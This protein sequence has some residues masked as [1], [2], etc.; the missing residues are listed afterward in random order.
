VTAKPGPALLWPTLLS[1]AAFA[2]LIGLGTWQMQRKSWKDGLIAQ[3][4]ARTTAPPIA[5]AEAIERMRKAESL[6]YTR[7]VVTG[8]WLPGREQHYWT[9]TPAGPGWHIYAPLATTDGPIVIVNR[10]FVPDARRDPALRPE[11]PAPA[12]VQLVGLLRKAEVRTT[13]TPDNV[14]ARNIWYWRDLDGMARSMLADA[15]GP[16][17]PFF[18]D[19][20]RGSA[21]PQAPQ[22]GVTRLDLP[23]THLQ[24]ALTWYGLAATLVGVYAA[25]AWGRLQQR[26]EPGRPPT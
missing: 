25:F 8:R 5:F 13:F 14:P 16:V 24:Y 7:V 20:E 23:N 22:G 12:A 11:P 19:A 3:I 21:P 2:V 26:G 9:A 1:V 6:E 15:T 17:A 4:A 10:G 18:L